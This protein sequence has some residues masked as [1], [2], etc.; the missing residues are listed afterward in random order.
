VASAA[1]APPPAAEPLPAAEAGLR[2]D[3][4]AEDPRGA[5][6]AR[7]Q[8][9]L[10]LLTGEA[11]AHA[12]EQICTLQKALGQE[13]KARATLQVLLR[14]YPHSPEAARAAKRLAGPAN[15]RGE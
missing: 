11:R 5:E 8:A 14:D 13:A 6:L 10:P 15:P 3:S 1:A 2:A 7:L 9:A 4:A 12:L